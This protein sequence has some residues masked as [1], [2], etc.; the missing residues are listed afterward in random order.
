MIVTVYYVIIQKTMSPRKSEE[1]VKIIVRVTD[2]RYFTRSKFSRSL[3][4]KKNF[5]LI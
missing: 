2:I 4:H 1:D 5:S 3:V